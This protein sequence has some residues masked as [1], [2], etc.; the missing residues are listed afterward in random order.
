M[1]E[2]PTI[3]YKWSSIYKILKLEN[4]TETTTKFIAILKWQRKKS[5]KHLF[6]FLDNIFKDKQYLKKFYT[7]EIF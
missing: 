1:T 4:E 2:N 5:K 7:G 3:L 6:F